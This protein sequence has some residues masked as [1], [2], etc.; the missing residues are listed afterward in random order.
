MK[1]RSRKRLRDDEEV[2]IFSEK[3]PQY[4]WLNTLLT[5]I[6]LVMIGLFAYMF[7]NQLEGWWI[8]GLGTIALSWATLAFKEM[9]FELTKEAV[10]AWFWPFRTRIP[11]SEIKSVEV[12]PRPWWQISLGL[13]FYY[14]TIAYVT[15]Y[16]PYVIVTREGRVFSK[17]ALTTKNPKEF[18]NRIKKMI[19]KRRLKGRKDEEKIK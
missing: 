9:H 4:W 15:R 8:M 6:T 5:L 1:E 14:N 13:R 11:Y 2:V 3:A 17:V 10:F 16:Q 18:A 12:K 7:I 19:K